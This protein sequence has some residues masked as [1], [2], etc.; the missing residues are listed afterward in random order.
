MVLAICAD[1]PTEMLQHQTPDQYQGMRQNQGDPKKNQV[2]FLLVSRRTKLKLC[3]PTSTKPAI[4]LAPVLADPVAS[5][6]PVRASQGAA[7]ELASLRP[8]T[9]AEGSVLK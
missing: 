9:S 8:Q 7:N 4:Q 6:R 5:I 3:T 2:A 1:G